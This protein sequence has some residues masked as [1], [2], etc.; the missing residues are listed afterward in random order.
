MYFRCRI[1]RGR[2]YLKLVGINYQKEDMHSDFHHIFDRTQ[3]S[4]A[5]E[6]C[7]VTALYYDY[8][9]E[10]NLPKRQTV[11]EWFYS[12]VMIL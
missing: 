6:S 4:V 8:I 2:K 12:A 3:L 7:S 5:V 11:Y 1:V 9:L 10:T